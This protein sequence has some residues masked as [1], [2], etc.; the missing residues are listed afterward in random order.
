[1]PDPALEKQM[2]RAVNRG[3]LV[4]APALELASIEQ[5]LSQSNEMAET[6]FVDELG[7]GMSHEL[8][9]VFR[10]PFALPPS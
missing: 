2:A 5:I 10:L 1:M 3:P 4:Q 7:Q 8:L 9:S 6:L